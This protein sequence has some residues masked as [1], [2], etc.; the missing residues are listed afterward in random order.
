MGESVVNR[1]VLATFGGSLYKLMVYTF[2]PI[3]GKC[4]IFVQ[5]DSSLVFKVLKFIKFFI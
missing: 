4:S 3:N 1:E 2:D 5:I